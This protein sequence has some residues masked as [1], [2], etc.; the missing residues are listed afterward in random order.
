MFR[1]LKFKL[2]AILLVLAILTPTASALAQVGIQLAQVNPT[3]SE[4]LAQTS[5]SA[6]DE[7]FEGFADGKRQAGMT[8]AS[9]LG[10]GLLAGGLLGLLGTGIGYYIVGPKDI[11]VHILTQ[12]SAKSVEYQSGFIKG[13]DKE[14]ERKKRSSFL[15][16]GLL[17]T[18][19]TM[20]VLVLAY[21][22]K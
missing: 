13:W 17:G 15:K 1:L 9:K 20:V 7:E 10:T 5:I 16:G 21:Q 3:S 12:V 2:V 18:C 19:A 11:E 22:S 4:E 6:N 8:K 14:T